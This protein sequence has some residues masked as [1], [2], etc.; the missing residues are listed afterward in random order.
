MSPERIVIAKI[1]V[2]E[3]GVVKSVTT[4]GK[5][6]EGIA[7]GA[8]VIRGGRGLYSGGAY[9]SNYYHVDDSFNRLQVTDKFPGV[10]QLLGVIVHKNDDACIVWS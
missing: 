6:V 10:P 8:R 7:A 4:T 1:E 3:K 5:E 9:A 2:D